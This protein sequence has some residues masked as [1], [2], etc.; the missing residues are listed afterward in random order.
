MW[1]ILPVKNLDTAKQRLADVLSPAERRR[2]FRAMFEDVLATLSGVSALKGVVVVSRDPVAEDLARGYGA[3]VIGEDVNRGHTAAVSMAAARLAGE[4]ISGM[5][6]VPADVP[7]ATPAEIDGVLAIHGPGPGP[8]MTIVPA[9]DQRGSNC[10]ACSPPDW[11]P[12]HFGDGS[13]TAHL[14]EAR[15]RRIEPRVL[16]L[17]GLGLDIDTPEDLVALLEVPGDTRTHAY[18]AD[19][20]IRRRL[21]GGAAMTA[22]RSR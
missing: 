13:Y 18:L 5:I 10:I 15:S 21:G 17:P 14:E 16:H 3:R 22:V 11:L 8:A 2:L 20:G 7:L 1:A 6:T 4:G 12:F 9:R 19:S